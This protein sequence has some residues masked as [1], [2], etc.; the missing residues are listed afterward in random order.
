MIQTADQT[1]DHYVVCVAQFFQEAISESNLDE[2]EAEI[3]RNK[4][5]KVTTG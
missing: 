1:D 2:M 4:L 3:L 5:Y